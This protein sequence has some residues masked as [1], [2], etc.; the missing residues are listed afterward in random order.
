MK[1]TVELSKQPVHK[2]WFCVATPDVGNIPFHGLLGRGST[3]EAAVRDFRRRV[4]LESNCDIATIEAEI[5][6]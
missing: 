4:A 1:L 5:V 3:R 2:T 6:H